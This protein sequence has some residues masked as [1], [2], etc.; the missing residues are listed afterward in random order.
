MPI[1]A[2][3]RT[4]LRRIA[5][6]VAGT[7]AVAAGFVAWA[8]HR[9]AVFLAQGRCSGGAT[10]KK[11]TLVAYATRSGSTGE[12]AKVISERL[13]ALGFDAEVQPVE[14]VSSLSGYQ[15]VVLGSAV[16][17]GAWLPEMTK[18]IESQRSA[19]A[20]LPLAVFTL[21]MQALG[22]DA[23]SQA[24]RAGY[25]QAVRAVLSPRDEVFF[26]GKV[27]PSTLSFFERMAVKLVKSPV[28]DKRDW[29]RIRRWADGL[30]ES[31]Q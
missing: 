3:R 16:R 26:A 23:A 11:K 2:S 9:P 1:E 25:T 19:L 10:V 12:V 13:C 31:L 24:A 30:G 29:D 21:H 8:V 17:Y 6:V 4:A 22:D 15:A 20:P 27:D 7:V 28:G 18:F 14:S 5:A